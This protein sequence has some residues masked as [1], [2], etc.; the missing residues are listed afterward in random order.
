MDFTIVSHSS[1]IRRLR[2]LYWP[3]VNN[4]VTN[5]EIFHAI[6]RCFMRLWYQYLFKRTFLLVSKPPKYWYTQ[7]CR[8]PTGMFVTHLPCRAF[9]LPRWRWSRHPGSA[10]T[11]RYQQGGRR[12]RRTHR[13]CNRQRRSPPVVHPWCSQHGAWEPRSCETQWDETRDVTVGTSHRK[14]FSIVTKLLLVRN[15]LSEVLLW[16]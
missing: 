4:S 11:P 12:W 7:R 2:L 8:S 16:N 9:W 15:V 6:C 13:R 3:P 1:Q 10:W 14:Q 5:T